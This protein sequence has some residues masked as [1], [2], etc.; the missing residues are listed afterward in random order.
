MLRIDLFLLGRSWSLILSGAAVWLALAGGVASMAGVTAQEPRREL[1]DDE[2]DPKGPAQEEDIEDKEEDK[3]KDER[4]AKRRALAL[5]VRELVRQLDADTL[6][7][8]DAA[9]QEL[10]KLG[11]TIVDLLPPTN[12]NMPG[13][14]RQR[15]TRISNAIQTSAANISGDPSKVTLSGDIRLDEALKELEQQSG[16]PF[17][18]ATGEVVTTGFRNE[19]YLKAVDSLLDQAN[20]TVRMYGG[21]PGTLTLVERPEDEAPR[22]ERAVYA[23]AFRLEPLRV[24]S[25]RNL[26]NPAVQGCRVA[27]RVEWEPRLRPISIIQ[28]L[29]DLVVTD[30]L[31]NELSVEGQGNR[32]SEV[33]PGASGIELELPFSLPDRKAAKIASLKGKLMALVPGRVETFQFNRRLDESAGM[34]LRKAGC[35]VVLDRVR[36]NGDLHQVMVRVRFDEAREALESHRGWFMQN[37]AFIVDAK[38]RRIAHASREQYQQSAEEVGVSY[39]FAL[40]DGL[41]GCRFVYRSP[42]MILQLPVEYEVKD[43]PLP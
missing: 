40:E 2:K 30:D 1:A 18:G 7:E 25:V 21:E 13:D 42:S 16:N 32:G 3:G 5:K 14:V 19:L 26:R 8:R 43:I 34:E 9:E 15:L 20:L 10:T 4:E 36:K 41:D 38:G 22:A 17:S 24:Q 11:A 29:A 6:K 28:S 23:G 31:G 39:Y 35:T 37:E 33:L 12:R 27:L